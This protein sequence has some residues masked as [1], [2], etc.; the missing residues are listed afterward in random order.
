MENNK[1]PQ[2]TFTKIPNV[3]LD[4]CDLPDEAIML[5]SRLLRQ[6]GHKGNVFRG[7]IR[8]LASVVQVKRDKAHRNLKALKV[9][10][11]V[12]TGIDSDLDISA[13]ELQADD[14][15]ELNTAYND[16]IE[17]PRWTDLQEVLKLVRKIRQEKAKALS[18]K[19]DTSSEKPDNNVA[20]I[21]QSDRETGQGV[22]PP[23]HKAP[24]KND[25]N[26]NTNKT[27]EEST[28]SQASPFT[29]QEKQVYDNYCLCFKKD[30]PRAPLPN[31]TEKFVKDIVALA[32]GITTQEEMQ[33]LFAYAKARIRGD[34]PRV[35]PANLL[36]WID[37]WRVEWQA[38]TF[39]L[40]GPTETPEPAQAVYRED[41]PL[42]VDMQMWMVD[43]ANEFGSDKTACVN[44]LEWCFQHTGCTEEEFYSKLIHAYG[45]AEKSKC[46]DTLFAELK[47]SLSLIVESVMVS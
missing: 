32:G 34:N 41:A 23:E 15:W 26:I 33:S 25:K 43:T 39:T 1:A 12:S 3:L 45:I 6:V 40:P 19:S 47:Q 21:G 4:T 42:P 16:G 44:E 17:V 9:A 10:K 38:Q 11:L 37:A 20:N 36:Y 22:R 30:M 13:I 31:A 28:L 2:G 5:F 35:Y 7:S 8:K 27:T 18:E 29:S 14:L 24:A 46:M